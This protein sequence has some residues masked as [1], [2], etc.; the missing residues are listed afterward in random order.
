MLKKHASRTADS[1]VELHGS[2][3]SAAVDVIPSDDSGM[4]RRRSAVR[5]GLPESNPAA[6]S[7]IV[8]PGYART[9]LCLSVLA[10]FAEGF[11]AY[12]LALYPTADFPLETIVVARKEALQQP[13]SRDL[14]TA[15][16]LHEA[17]LLSVDARL[18]G[19]P[20]PDASLPWYRNLPALIY[21]K[22]AAASWAYWRREREIRKAVVALAQFDDRSLRDMGISSRSEIEQVVRYCH[23]C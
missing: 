14:A 17:N 7:A 2:R 16:R 1:F 11:G 13:G 19:G 6:A 23:D 21:D 18:G 9:S 12:S 8:R 22:A 20:A 4:A 5:S 15:G 10:A 3:K